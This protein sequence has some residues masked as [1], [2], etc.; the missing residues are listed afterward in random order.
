[1]SYKMEWMIVCLQDDVYCIKMS[2]SGLHSLEVIGR[3]SGQEDPRNVLSLAK[4]KRKR[5]EDSHGRKETEG[6][7]SL[8]RMNGRDSM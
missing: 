2:I 3:G 5:N 1:M 8:G 4:A 6:E 7:F